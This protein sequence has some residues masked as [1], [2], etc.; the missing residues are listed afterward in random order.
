M[1]DAGH[2][3]HAIL[4]AVIDSARDAVVLV[5]DTGCVL[6][7]NRAAEQMFGHSGTDA[8]GQNVHL[9]LAP[10]AQRDAALAC[11]RRFGATGNGEAIGRTVEMD[12]VRRDG[13]LLRVELSLTAVRV[14]AVWYALAV[15]RDITER[16]RLEELLRR[17]E[18]NFHNVVEMNRSG[19][20]VVD[21]EGRIRFA[22]AA[23]QQLLNRSVEELLGLPFGVPSTT[24]R[25][26]MAV[27]RKDGSA[28]TAEMSATQ[29][30]WEQQPAHLVMLH[31]ITDLKEAESRARFLALHDALTGLPNRRLF[32][33]RLDHGL[34]QAHGSGGRVAVLFM[35]LDRF[36]PI[37]DS[38]GHEAGDAVLRTV[39]KRIEQSLRASDTV[40]RFGGDEFAAVIPS[41]ET[42]AD[43]DAVLRTLQRCFDAPM[44]VAGDELYVR[45][46]IGAA[47]YPDDGS[48]ANTLLRRAD[49]AM[50]AAKRGGGA[51]ARLFSVAMES[52][53][54][55]R[56]ELERRLHGALER[57]E[58][59]LVYQPQVRV[60]DGALC[61][62][63]ALLRWHSPVLGKVPPDR[64]VPMLEA[65]GGIV[66]VGAWVLEEACRQL[67]AWRDDGHDPPPT[68]VNVSAR[69]L[70]D[71]GFPD[72]V[73]RCL[74]EYRIAPSLLTLEL[75]E[76]ALV[77]DE[78]AA[79]EALNRLA[80][81]GI[82]LHMDDFGTGYSSLGLLR[83]LPF[84]T[85]KIDRSYVARITENDDDA[86]LV[87]GIISMA[88]S[89]RKSTLAEGVETEQQLELL[90]GYRCD[91]AQG[92]LFGHPL[93]PAQ[94]AGLFGR[95]PA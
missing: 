43:V 53:D 88:H 21:A 12:A 52:G 87:A 92:W 45:A 50:Y 81:L 76:T 31:D 39:A 68:A 34:R 61:G 94:L 78:S 14:D 65:N 15:I 63:E 58:L 89:L 40:G 85:V 20:L 22:N 13:G 23:A 4:D 54:K 42:V 67:A 28:G 60:G 32:L 24:L 70:A 66:A 9:L 51:T 56:L 47:L 59:R 38:L 1:S 64:F 62:C 44:R 86:L 82:G 11:M 19:I 37:N 46:S 10:P 3:N 29:T 30:L 27:L 2:L 25:Q 84:D 72:L 90:R 6:R 57:G 26:E 7:W 16:C 83:R 17:S 69:Q 71:L 48:D 49:D 93:A 91:Y 79:T 75:T 74:G 18:R 41:V 5:D 73:E 35:D 8:H 95:G 33:E 77:D 80:D 36:K 55:D